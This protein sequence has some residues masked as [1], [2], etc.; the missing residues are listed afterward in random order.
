[1]SNGAVA[2]VGLAAVPVVIIPVAYYFWCAVFS[3]EFPL[4]SHVHLVV[5][6]LVVAGAGVALV[7]REGVA[8]AGWG[9][10]P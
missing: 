8:S 10:W 5:E 3:G 7:G 4:S 2:G 1:M 9:P 6:A